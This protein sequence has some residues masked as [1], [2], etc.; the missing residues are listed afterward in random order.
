MFMNKNKRFWT[1][2]AI[3][4]EI[5][6]NGYTRT[7][8]KSNPLDIITL[9]FQYYRSLIPS[10]TKHSLYEPT[11]NEHH[12]PYDDDKWS[13]VTGIPANKQINTALNKP[14]RII[15]EPDKST[16]WCSNSKI[17]SNGIQ[18]SARYNFS[19]KYIENMFNHSI[20]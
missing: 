20:I 19:V 15:F 6:T 18:Y 8:C 16:K 2:E 1:H 14:F 3:I 13:S 17:L 11:P 5:L 10:F 12:H 9:I 7:I 4:A